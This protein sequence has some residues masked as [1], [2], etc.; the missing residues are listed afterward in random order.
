MTLWLTRIQPD[1]R[2]RDVR[3]DLASAVGMHHRL[4]ML[5]PDDLGPTA[6]NTLGVL[7]RIED[8]AGPARSPQILL[9]S[10]EHP[11]PSRL[12]AGYGTTT[13]KDISALISLLKNGLAVRYRIDANPVRKP[14]H[15]TRAATGAKA[16][17]PLSGTDADDWWARQ[18]EERSGLKL[19][20]THTTPLTAARGERHQDKH[21]IRHTRTRFEGTA[22]V[23]DHTTLQ[24]R[25]LEGIGRG[26]S[27]GCG[28]LSLAP[29]TNPAR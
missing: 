1:L 20:S 22:I 19:T 28:L 18:A 16:V 8:T 26:K 7:F 11:D 13:T 23:T 25:I 6:R 10:R 9:Q 17:I 27:Y 15:T 3:R 29:L 14:G 12:P 4:M 24:Q 21:H 2:H 5:F